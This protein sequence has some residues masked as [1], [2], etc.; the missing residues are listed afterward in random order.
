MTHRGL[1]GYL[2][3]VE[4]FFCVVRMSG[5]V[6][7]PKDAEKVRRWYLDGIPMRVVLDGIAQGVRAHARSAA[8]GERSPHSLAY[9]ARYI[10]ARVRGF[11]KAGP[12]PHDAEASCVPPKGGLNSRT[13]GAGAVLEHLVSEVGLLVLPE[14]RET[15][16]RVKERVLEGLKGLLERAGELDEGALSYEL[17]RLDDDYL[18]FYDSALTAG[19]RGEV[20]RMVEGKLRGEKGL[21]PRAVE[22]RRKALRANV[23]RTRLNILDMAE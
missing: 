1:G 7:S 19:E 23:L 13:S 21:S 6:L 16:R 9:Y 4:R 5:L 17:Q 20:D 8:R 3:D 2:G 14:E 22:G 18:G 10:G 12:P 11:R 15:E